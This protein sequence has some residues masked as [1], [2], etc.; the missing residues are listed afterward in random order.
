MKFSV[1]LQCKHSEVPQSSISTSSFLLPVLFRAYIKPPVRINKMVNIS[2][3]YH[4]H[5]GCI[6]HISINYLGLY[7]SPKSLLNFLWNLYIPP[8]LRK[9]F[10]NLRKCIES[11]HFYSCLPP[12]TQNSFPTSQLIPQAVFL[13]KSVYLINRKGWRKLWFASSK[14]NQKIYMMMTYDLRLFIFCMISSDV[15][16]LQF[17]KWS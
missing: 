16:A 12:L 15:M 6:F 5:Q 17:C 4:Q 8:W 2:V 9:I 13:Q 14:L 3:D 11:R 10:H 1:K 7:L